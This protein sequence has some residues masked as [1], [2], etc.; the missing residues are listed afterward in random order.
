MHRNE[1][2]LKQAAVFSQV[3]YHFFKFL[4]CISKGFLTGADAYPAIFQVFWLVPFQIVFIACSMSALDLNPY[5]SP[6]KSILLIV[7]NLS[8][9]A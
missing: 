6:C 1:C 2:N 8:T 7:S 5:K 4:H 3:V 9:L